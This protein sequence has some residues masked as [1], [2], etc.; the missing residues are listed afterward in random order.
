MRA[1]STLTDRTS[2]LKGAFEHALVG[3]GYRD[4]N[5]MTSL[6]TKLGTLCIISVWNLMFCASKNRADLFSSLNATVR[7]G[8][9]S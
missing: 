5:H 1:P 9:Y 6:A 7:F 3:E 8:C 4:E 2:F